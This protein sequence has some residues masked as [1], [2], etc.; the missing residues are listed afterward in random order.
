CT[1][2]IH[3]DNGQ[4]IKLNFSTFQMEPQSEVNG[5]CYDYLEIRNGRRSD[6]PLIGKFCGN[7]PLADIVSHSNYL[8][9]RFI[10]DAS[11][12]NRGF[13]GFYQTLESGCGGL[14]TS[15]SGSIESPDY[16]TSYFSNMNCEWQIR[17]S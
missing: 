2:I 3:V 8:F 16:P 12:Q 1:W 11:M 5:Q 13:E 17:I 14:M 9:L 10:S 7:R 6:S 15:E 4:Q